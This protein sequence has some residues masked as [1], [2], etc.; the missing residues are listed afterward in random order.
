MVKT[1]LTRRVNFWTHSAFAARVHAHL[2]DLVAVNGN[3]LFDFGKRRPALNA[4]GAGLVDVDPPAAL[5]HPHGFRRSAPTAQRV[6]RVITT[7]QLPF[8]SSNHTANYEAP[9]LRLKGAGGVVL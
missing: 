1:D 9:R 7:H 4:S 5:A 6:A 8:H 3:R 2:V